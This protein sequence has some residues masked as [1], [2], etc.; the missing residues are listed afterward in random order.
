VDTAV[1]PRKVNILN[2]DF[3]CVSVEEVAASVDEHIRNGQRGWICT[4]NVS[5]LMI[6]RSHRALQAHVDAA[7]LTIADGQPIVWASRLLGPRLP[8]RTAGV[9]VM[10]RLCVTASQR[11]YPV[12]LLGSTE[13]NVIAAG[14]QLRAKNPGLLLHTHC[15]YFRDSEAAAVAD[16]IRNSGATLLFV[17]MGVPRQELFIDRQWDRLGVAVAMGVGGS[18]DVLSG[19]LTRAPY[20]M[21]KCGLEWT[22][23]LRQEP[24][25]LLR[26]YLVTGSQFAA[27]MACSLMARLTRATPA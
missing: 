15:G 8:E 23:R 27:L 11:G 4:V 3:D 24:V 20:W 18:F 2:A 6:M 10:E 22:H 17:G 12:F 21:Q 5:Y 1:S 14:N 13:A 16:K 9:D 26:R 25:R 19:R 7:F